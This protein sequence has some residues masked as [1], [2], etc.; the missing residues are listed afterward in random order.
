[1]LDNNTNKEQRN[2]DNSINLTKQK[3]FVPLIGYWG[4]T[5]GHSEIKLH[6]HMHTTITH[7]ET[8]TIIYINAHT[9]PKLSHTSTKVEQ[10]QCRVQRNK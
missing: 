3:L 5:D 1:M 10:Y 2:R 8:D 4:Q 6:K 7:T 9:Q